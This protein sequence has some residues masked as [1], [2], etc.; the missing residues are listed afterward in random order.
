MCTILAVVWLAHACCPWQP[1]SLRGLEF[2]LVCVDCAWQLDRLALT[3]PSVQAVQHSHVPE[4]SAC[5]CSTQQA[6]EPST[7]GQSQSQQCNSGS[8]TPNL[9]ASCAGS[10]QGPPEAGKQSLGDSLRVLAQSQQIRCLGVMALSQGLTTNLVDIVWKT[11]LHMLH[12]DP[13][14]YAVGRSLV[15]PFLQAVRLLPP[16]HSLLPPSHR[17]KHGRHRGL[18]ARPGQPVMDS[19]GALGRPRK[20]RLALRRGS[21]RLLQRRSAVSAP[22]M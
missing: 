21:Q 14:H 6:G 3:W 19:D 9:Q 5:A 2:S 11:H 10:A 8:Q 17:S 15:P 20:R 22:C 12:P 7:Q 16:L 18:R 1:W 4:L 13:A